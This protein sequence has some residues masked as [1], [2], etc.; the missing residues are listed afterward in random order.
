MPSEAVQL[1]A[2]QE[3]AA[4]DVERGC[5]ALIMACPGAGKTTFAGALARRLMAMNG[6]DVLVIT[7][8]KQLEMDLNEKAKCMGLDNLEASTIHG[9]VGRQSGVQC[10]DDAEMLRIVEDASVRMQSLH[11]AVLYIDEAQDLRPLF[12]E[13][14]LK[15]FA[16]CV[17]FPRMVVCGDEHQMLY[18]FNS[19][20]TDRASSRFLQCA[21]EVFGSVSGQREW[22]RHT[23][24]K[25][26]R[27][28]PNI[29]TF[30]NAWWGTHIE[31]CN[32]RVPNLKVHYIY[33][34]PYRKELSHMI[35]QSIAKYGRDQPPP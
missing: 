27:L 6:G 1:T 10:T 3:A 30:V 4:R 26:F 18:D 21:P 17:G 28:T 9:L 20:G 33:M 24:T 12:V 15:V 13:A 11:K 8:N 31:G 2:E 7:Y 19:L 25:S 35:E 34:N 32:H 14:L 29:A 5:C 16:S 23:F 22:T